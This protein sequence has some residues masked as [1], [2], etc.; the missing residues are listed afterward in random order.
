MVWRTY[1]L[2][3]DVVRV[4]R[5]AHALAG[6][7]ACPVDVATYRPGVGGRG[8]GRGGGRDWGWDTV[9][10]GGHHVFVDLDLWS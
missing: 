8:R 2:A 5:A 10:G 6:R 7:V 3:V 4:S 1:P 9:G